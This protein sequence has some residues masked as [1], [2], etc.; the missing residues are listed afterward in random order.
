MRCIAE[1]HGVV[2]AGAVVEKTA[3]PY[4]ALIGSL[5]GAYRDCAAGRGQAAPESP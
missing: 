1:Q 5:R 4:A 3:L 2:F